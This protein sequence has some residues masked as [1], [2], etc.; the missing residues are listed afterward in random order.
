MNYVEQIELFSTMD[1]NHI[2]LILGFNF[3]KSIVLFSKRILLLII[4]D[5]Y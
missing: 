1:V 3:E 4:S 2:L 5:Q